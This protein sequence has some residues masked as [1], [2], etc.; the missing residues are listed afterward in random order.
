M[1]TEES[2]VK[3]TYLSQDGEILP[4]F[5]KTPHNHDTNA[6]SDRTALLTTDKS[7]T[8]QQFKEDAD[9]NVILARYAAKKELPPM[10]L[11]EHFTDLSGGRMTYIDIQTRLAE[12][13]A[14]FYNLPPATRYEFRNDPAAWAQAV[15]VATEAGSRS[16]LRE[17]GID[18]PEP[19]EPPTP[20]GGP[21]APAPEKGPPSGPKTPPSGGK[22]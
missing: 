19:V 13:N 15:M 18:A 5:F 4:L 20:A 6:E 14:M 9:I 21:P 7:L 16:K 2:P 22:D 11:P 12:A 8:Q 17:L 1:E 10:A 3:L